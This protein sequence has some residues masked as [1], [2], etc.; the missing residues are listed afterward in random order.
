MAFPCEIE[1]YQ[2][3]KKNASNQGLQEI[4]DFKK[5]GN[6]A[7]ID[8]LVQELQKIPSFEKLTHDEIQI[9]MGFHPNQLPQSIQ[10]DVI[11]GAWER[12]CQSYLSSSEANAIKDGIIVCITKILALRIWGCLLEPRNISLMEDFFRTACINGVVET[13]PNAVASKR[14]VKTSGSSS[15]IHHFVGCAIQAVQKVA[16]LDRPPLDKAAVKAFDRTTISTDEV[17]KMQGRIVSDSLTELIVADQAA[18]VS[19]Q[20]AKIEETFIIDVFSNCKS[21]NTSIVISNVEDQVA[22]GKVDAEKTVG[23]LRIS[24]VYPPNSDSASSFMSKDMNI[25]EDFPPDLLFCKM[26]STWIKDEDL[27]LFKA[28]H[29]KSLN[30]LWHMQSVKEL[31]QGTV[32]DVAFHRVERYVAVLMIDDD[33]KVALHVFQLDEHRNGFNKV[34]LPDLSKLQLS[35]DTTSMTFCCGGKVLA[36]L[37]CKTSTITTLR[38]D[39]QECDQLQVHH[40][41]SDGTCTARKLLSTAAGELLIV[42]TRNKCSGDKAIDEVLAPLSLSVDVRNDGSETFQTLASQ[43][44]DD[45]DLT[46]PRSKIDAWMEDHG[47]NTTEH[48]DNNSDVMLSKFI[49]SLKS[50]SDESLLKLMNIEQN[51][52]KILDLHDGMELKGAFEKTSACIIRTRSGKLF[53]I[54]KHHTSVH[55]FPVLVSFFPPQCLDP[56]PLCEMLESDVP[57]ITVVA[58][59]KWGEAFVW[60]NC[61]LQSS[62]YSKKHKKPR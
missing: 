47:Q 62:P 11:D 44:C 28:K 37:N 58:H 32:V 46:L 53:R 49:M 51:N 45:V 21:G 41:L 15:N 55:V 9:M 22:S 38:L 48:E 57:S 7:V 61:C 52:V 18:L 1:R 35:T 50:P 31:C 6:A 4:S 27:I 54:Q 8:G 43:I 59:D 17:L 60:S 29:G 30:M 24:H 34:M 25:H 39:T 12:F 10:I 33:Q 42:A 13:I 40:R 3:D 36:F 14:V 26:F 5:L 2:S 56:V 20:V 23:S 19:K 16:K